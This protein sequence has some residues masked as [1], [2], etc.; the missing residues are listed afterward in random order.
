MEKVRSR[1]GAMPTSQN[2]DMGHPV[3]R[4]HRGLRGHLDLCAANGLL[5]SRWVCMWRRRLGR[6]GGVLWGGGGGMGFGGG[7]GGFG[8]A[9]FFVGGGQVGLGFVGGDVGDV[10]LGGGGVDD[11]LGGGVIAP[12]EY[13]VE[14]GDEVLGE[15]GGEGF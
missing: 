11:G 8:G 9:G 3:L 14:V 2:R 4:E 13:G 15:T 6:G 12:G 10:F 1:W 5:Y 7:G